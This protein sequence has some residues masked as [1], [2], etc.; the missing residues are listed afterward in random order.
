MLQTQSEQLNRQGNEFFSRGQ[1]TEAYVCYAKALEHDRLSGDRQALAASLG[2]LGNICAVSGRCEQAQSYYQEVLALQKILGDERGIGTTLANLGNLRADAGEWD[3]ARAYYL[4]AQDLMERSG[5]VLGLA[6]LFSDLGLVDRETG[7]Y[8]GAMRYYE[9][10]L[11]LM[12]RL[13]NQGG[14]AD[15]WRMMACT[16]V[17]QKKYD[18]ALACC[19]TSQAIAERARD[20]LRAGGARYVM[21]LC[22][23][24]LGQLKD[25]AELLEQ[26]VRMDRKYRLPKLEENTR[27]L[28]TLRARLAAGDPSRSR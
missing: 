28:E 1:Y 25:A 11:A 7:H 27:R 14:T 13:D 3:R 15:A 6:V 20:E 21:S 2:N 8:E 22:H 26:V 23:E 16:Y 4:E 9:Q 19:R 12:R 18:E 10:S 24:E 5:D 17:A